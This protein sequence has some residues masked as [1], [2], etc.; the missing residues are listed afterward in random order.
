MISNVE[1]GISNVEFRISRSEIP[2]SRFDI[3]HSNFELQY[4]TSNIVTEESSSAGVFSMSLTLDCSEPCQSFA[5]KE[6][7]SSSSPCAK[8]VTVPSGSLRT[9]PVRSWDSATF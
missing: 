3:R 4:L 7:R 1:C 6:S 5:V 8:T 9:Q 2:Y